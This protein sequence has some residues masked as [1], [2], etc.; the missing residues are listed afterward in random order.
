MGRR[1]GR[2]GKGRGAMCLHGRGGG[3]R[4]GLGKKWRGAHLK[5]RKHSNEAQE[6]KQRVCF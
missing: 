6:K 3:G 1:E 5:V 4:A 2:E